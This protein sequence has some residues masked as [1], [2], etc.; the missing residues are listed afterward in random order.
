MRFVDVDLFV[1]TVHE[2]NIYPKIVL[3]IVS[4]LF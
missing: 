2:I 3:N 4:F 1:K